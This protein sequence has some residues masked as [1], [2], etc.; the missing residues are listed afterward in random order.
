MLAA[1]IL[2]VDDRADNLFALEAMLEGLVDNLHFVKARSGEQALECVLNQDFAVI[3]LDVWLPGISGLETASLIKTRERSQHTPIIFLTAFD[4][5]E[6]PIFKGYSS[7]AVDYLIKPIVPEVLRAKVATFF[8]S[9]ERRVGK[10]CR[11][12]GAPYH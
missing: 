4:Q 3:L 9:E 10:E 2:L 12:R 7:G 11:S 6:L 8:R 1:N 5:G